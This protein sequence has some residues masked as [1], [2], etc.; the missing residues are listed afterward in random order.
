MNHFSRTFA[1]RLLLPQRV[2]VHVEVQERRPS[3]N[4]ECVFVQWR[5][6]VVCAMDGGVRVIERNTSGLIGGFC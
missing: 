6:C 4:S 2:Q 5:L 3:C 1:G